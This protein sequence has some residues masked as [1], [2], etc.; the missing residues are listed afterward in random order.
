MVA[1]RVRQALLERL[2]IGIVGSQ[3]RC[4]ESDDEGHGGKARTQPQRRATS[5]PRPSHRLFPPHR[6][7]G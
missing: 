4:G 7:R 2:T 6:I 1:G 3:P 5:L